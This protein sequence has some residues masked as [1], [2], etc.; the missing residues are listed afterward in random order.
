M[1]NLRF[2]AEFIVFTLTL[3]H[4]T[5]LTLTLTHTLTLTLT[6]TLTSYE[7]RTFV[8]PSGTHEMRHEK[9]VRRKK[10]CIS[11]QF[12]ANTFPNSR[13]ILQTFFTRA[14]GHVGVIIPFEYG[15]HSKLRSWRPDYH[16]LPGAAIGLTHC[17][18][19]RD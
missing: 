10:F 11:S 7:P 19:L 4:N 9:A 16:W 5:T 2:E 18:Q 17:K 13:V 15:D 6:L 14:A 8:S 12:Q 1:R 3:T